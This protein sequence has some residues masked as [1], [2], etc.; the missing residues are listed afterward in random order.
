ML[1]EL[2]EPSLE[3]RACDMVI[4]YENENKHLFDE[5]T[6]AFNQIKSC[7]PES[8]LPTLFAMENCFA[9]K[10]LGGKE[11]YK[12]GFRH[13]MHAVIEE[14]IQGGKRSL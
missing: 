3:E 5:F 9:Q 6:N 2:L 7:I 14:F 11:I 12:N 13:G 10:L 1:M 4:F 8:M